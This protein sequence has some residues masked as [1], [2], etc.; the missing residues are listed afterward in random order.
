MQ[1]I[2]GKILQL[3]TLRLAAAAK[4]AIADIRFNPY[5]TGK[6]Y[7]IAALYLRLIIEEQLSP[8][9][10]LVVTFTRAAT[11]EI[12]DRVR[13]KLIELKS[14]FS[15]GS[16]TDIFI[17]TLVKK[18]DN[19]AL[20]MRL[21]Q[22]A[23]FDFDKAAIFTIHGFCQRVLHENAFETRSLFDT[24]LVTDPTVLTQ[25]IALSQKKTPGIKIIPDI[26]QPALKSLPAFRKIY[27]KLKNLWPLSRT[28]V[29]Q[30]LKSPSLSGTIYGSL[31][32][33]SKQVGVSNRD[34][35]II[36]LVEAMDRFVDNKLAGFPLFK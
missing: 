4:S 7:T 6:T 13:N 22:D 36:S 23:L 33:E 30:L 18:H 8:H 17:D 1:G 34:L 12:K 25:E 20:A 14:A 35:K 10:I 26:G 29:I 31:T 21:I 9:Q 27:K 28:A 19:P 15:T 16:G 32:T 11:A 24:E 5:G 2:R 3:H